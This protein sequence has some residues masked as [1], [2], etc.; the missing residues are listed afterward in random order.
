MSR[1]TQVQYEQVASAC[2]ELFRAGD[3]VSF[4]KVYQR[5]GSRGGQQVVSDMIRRWRQEV[6]ERLLAERAHPQ[7]PPELVQASDGLVAALWQQA[8]GSA[9]QGYQQQVEA[10]AQREAD[11]QRKLDDS[12]V[13]VGQVDRENL[14]IK[15]QLAHVQGQLQA[16][17]AAHQELVQQHQGLQDQWVQTDRARVLA[18]EQVAQL[19][20]VMESEQLRYAQALEALKVQHAHEL[21]QVQVRADEDR[22]HLLQQTDELRQAHRAQAAQ[23]REQLAGERV[24]VETSRQQLNTAREAGA[25]WQGRAEVAQQE[26]VELKAQAAKAQEDASRWQGRADALQEALAVA[27]QQV[28]ALSERLG[29][30]NPAEQS[31]LLR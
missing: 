16:Q 20:G 11:W 14:E 19:Q 25:R 24:A 2:A 12:Q 27:R 29:E 22:R 31:S 8:L 23:L 28:D 15:A 30:R 6:A 9:Q 3:S 17:Q 26:L 13:Y 10:L 5:I 7:L 1:L 21:R 4:A 18:Q